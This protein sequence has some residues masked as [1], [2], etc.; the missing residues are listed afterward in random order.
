MIR[1]NK[2]TGFIGGVDINQ[3]KN[4]LVYWLIVFG[5]C[6]IFF[7]S[8][9]PPIWL[10]LS[11]LKDIKEF[12]M[13]PPTII[14]RSFHIEKLAQV[15]VE[16]K[17]SKYLINSLCVVSGSVVCALVFNGLLA[18]GISILKPRGS[19][20]VFTMVMWSM[21]VPATI[22]LVPLFKNIVT[23]KLVNSFIP[24]WFI[25]GANAFFV[26]LFKQF[27]DTIPRSLIE[28]A[29]IDGCSML[30]LFFKIILPLSRPVCA[31]V[32]IFALNQAWSDF[33][34]SYLVLREDSMQTIIVKLFNLA[35]VPIDYKMVALSFAV[36]PPILI[37]LVFQKNIMGGIGS[38]AIKG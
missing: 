24:L 32:M 22:S 25:F 2:S 8:V 28:A 33:L 29:N 13:V 27:F 11:S 7:V 1:I 20:V 10:M 36:I 34:V 16:L 12:F 6:I 19:K 21:M 31:V 30:G 15:W 9:L 38:G 5:A 14:P 3:P 18:Y 4:R 37:F 26:I 35:R 17:F 23:F